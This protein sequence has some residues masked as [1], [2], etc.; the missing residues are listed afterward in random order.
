MTKTYKIIFGT[1]IAFTLLLT[2]LEATEP[3][4]VNWTPSYMPADRIPLGS[5]VF[6]ESWKNTN[7]TRIEEVKIPPYEFLNQGEAPDGTYFFLN[8]GIGFDEDELNDLLAW[9]EKGNTAFISAYS[10]GK[11]LL[12][13]LNLET[14][15]YIDKKDFTSRPRLQLVHPSLRRDSSYSFTTDITAVYFSKLDSLHNTVL[16]TASFGKDS[17]EQVNFIKTGFGKGNIFLHTTPQAFS[18]YFMLQ[19]KNWQYAENILAYVDKEKTLF[20]DNYY[21]DGKSFYT[22]PLYVLLSNRELK[23]AYYIFL[24]AALLFVLFEGKRKQRAIPV[25]KPLKNQTYAYTATIGDMYLEQDYSRELGLKKIELFLEFIRTKYRIQTEKIDEGFYENLASASGNSYED[26][27]EL[28][29]RITKFKNAEKVSRQEFQ[30]LSQNIN[31][32]KRPTNG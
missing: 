22:S 28:F 19:N 27:K 24:L 1:L 3:V 23:W 11:E 32:F 10:L 20:W 25:V 8:S 30:D 2:Y 9:V 31:A 7:T 16:G 6:F 14:Q 13:T 15:H 4:P 29:E 17:I 18:N 21:K 26:T 5:Y 12:D